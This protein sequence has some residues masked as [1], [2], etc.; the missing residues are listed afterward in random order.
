EAFYLAGLRVANS[1]SAVMFALAM[2]LSLVLAAALASTMTAP[3]R[4]IARATRAM[5]AGDLTARASGSDVEELDGLAQSFND[6]AGRLQSSFDELVAEVETRKRR[7]RELEDS[8]TRLR[9]SEDRLH[10]A[11]DAAR[12]GIWD[13]D[14]EQDRLVWDDSMYQLYGVRK[15]EFSGAFDAW[16]RCV[17]PE[18]CAR[19]T[20]DVQAALRGERE[21]RS[22]F[23]IRRADGAIRAMRGVGQTIRGADGR[24]VRMVGVNWDV[25]DLLTAEREREQLVHDL[26]DR[27]KELRL[28]HATARL[29]QRDCPFNR[30]RLVE[31]VVLIPPAW[32]YPECCAARFVYGGL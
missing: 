16:S 2:V 20:E 7:E 27:V 15:E 1:R 17:V 8:E 32:Q 5:A 28:L 19:A 24:P 29:L 30:A 4:R 14:V 26:G 21:F 6:M 11:I 22:D 18:D 9:V 13:W 23:R 3:L 10:L 31:L 25:T 12:L